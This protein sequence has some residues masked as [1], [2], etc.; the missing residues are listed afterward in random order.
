MLGIGGESPELE[1]ACD[2]VVDMAT[3]VLEEAVDE[4]EDV[5]MCRLGLRSWSAQA[6]VDSEK[7]LSTSCC[8]C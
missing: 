3:R 8:C 2:E 5:R 6:Q 4:L 7:P 1:A